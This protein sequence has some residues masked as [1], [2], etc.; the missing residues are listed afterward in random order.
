VFGLKIR[1]APTVDVPEWA[2]RMALIDEEV[3]E[4]RAAAAAGDIVETADALA[5]IVYVVYG[6]ALTC[7]IDLGACLAECTARTWRSGGPTV[8]CTPAKTAK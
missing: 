2:M 8:S 3:E 5:D 1:T 7:G 4:L 6:A